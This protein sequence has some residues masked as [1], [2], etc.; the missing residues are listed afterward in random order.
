MLSDVPERGCWPSSPSMHSPSARLTLNKDSLR[1]SSAE[2]YSSSSSDVEQSPSDIESVAEAIVVS[3]TADE[4]NGPTA[5]QLHTVRR[6]PNSRLALTL[7]V[8]THACVGSRG[9]R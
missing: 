6:A 9:C 2:E 1:P 4:G 3:P 7:D 8:C 5:T